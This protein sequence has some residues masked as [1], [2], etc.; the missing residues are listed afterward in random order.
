M[1]AHYRSRDFGG[2]PYIDG[3]V[4]RALARLR[5]SQ[6]R[7]TAAEAFAVVG[8]VVLRAPS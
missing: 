1:V 3:E 6:I 2:R 8:R 5:G 4:V 7:E